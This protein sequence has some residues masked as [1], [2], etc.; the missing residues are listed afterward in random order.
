MERFYILKNKGSF[1]GI[2]D[3]TKNISIMTT[4]KILTW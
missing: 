1:I 2:Y 3:F 4:Q